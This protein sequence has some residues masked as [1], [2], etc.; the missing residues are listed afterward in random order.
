VLYSEYKLKYFYNAGWL[1]D[2][3]KTAETI[4][5]DKF[6]NSYASHS[7]EVNESAAASTSIQV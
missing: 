1:D 6:N 7:I 2:W 4:V 3:I 5:C